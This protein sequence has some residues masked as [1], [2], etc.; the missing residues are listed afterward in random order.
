MFRLNS[1]F[2]W[3]FEQNLRLPIRSIYQAIEY[4]REVNSCKA[5]ITRVPKVVEHH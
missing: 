1:E 3:N 2:F 4:K 5:A